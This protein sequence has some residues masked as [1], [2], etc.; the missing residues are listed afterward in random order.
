MQFGSW[1]SFLED[2]DVG[3]FILDPPMRLR[4]N[5]QAWGL[6]EIMKTI[7]IIDQSF[8]NE[9]SIILYSMYSQAEVQH[10]LTRDPMADGHR[11]SVSRFVIVKVRFQFEQS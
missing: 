10:A 11:L 2:Y 3:C 8:N 9:Y 1:T 7:N 6:L 5:T 4:K